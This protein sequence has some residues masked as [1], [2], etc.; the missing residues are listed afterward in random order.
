MG[1]GYRLKAETPDGGAYRVSLPEDPDR[2][3]LLMMR[4]WLDDVIRQTEPPRDCDRYCEKE[5]DHGD[6]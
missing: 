5:E 6:V 4:G 3:V 1:E 2:R